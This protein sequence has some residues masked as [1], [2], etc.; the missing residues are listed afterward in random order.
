[1][2][3]ALRRDDGAGSLLAVAVIGAVL[4]V[5][6]LL[7]PLYTVLTVRARAEGSADAA[8]LAAA[9]VA[10]GIVPGIPCAV[11]ADV[12]EANRARVTECQADGVI[13]TVRVS[14]TVLGFSVQSAATAGPPGAASK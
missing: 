9:D 1:M 8:A 4:A 13:V 10:I 2:E 6:F 7:V 12:A 5:T 11:A 14:I 3:K